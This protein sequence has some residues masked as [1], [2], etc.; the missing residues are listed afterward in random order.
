MA[1]DAGLDAM[2]GSADPDKL[3]QALAAA[4]Y[5]GERVAIL[6]ASDFPT[7]NAMA[8]VAAD[9]LKRIG[10]NVDYQSLDWGTVVQRRTSKEL[11]SKGGWNV[12]FTFLGGTGNVSPA[13]H[14]ALRSN[15][16]KAWFGWPDL[17]KVEALRLSWFD[18]PDLASQAEDRPRAAIAGVPG[19]ALRPDGHVLPADRVPADAQRHPRWLPQFYGV[20]KKS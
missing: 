11:P 14:L 10:F 16:A 9:M 2:K 6:A 17:P 19:C 5:K 8:Q 4:G 12:F 15:G 1:S 18:A 13:A 7:I 20:M 3:K